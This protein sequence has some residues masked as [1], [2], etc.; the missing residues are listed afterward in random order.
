MM[1]LL[2]SILTD[3]S[4]AHK[5]YSTLTLVTRDG[6]GVIIH[7]A[8]LLVLE[9]L[10]KL[11]ENTRIQLMWL[12]KELIKT[13]V[14]GTD[15]LCFAFLKQMPAG[16]T[17]PADVWLAENLL[18]LFL[19]NMA[20][21]EAQP[22]L[23]ISVVFTYLS[24]LPTHLCVSSLNQLKNEE[25]NFLISLLRNKFIE[26]IQ[27]GRDLIRLLQ[28]VS[29]VPEFTHFW[30]DLLHHPE[31][32]DPSF[33]GI[34]QVLS[35]RTSR[36]FV[37]GRI[38]TDSEIK[39]NFLLSKVKFGQHKR[40]QEW[41]SKKYLST[42]ES[43]TVIPELIR[44]V[45]CVIHPPNE[46]LGSDI[47]PRWA[48]IGWLLTLAQPHPVVLAD[49]KLALF[50]DWLNYS[51]NTDN[52]MNIEPAA[53]LMF[54]SLRSHPQMTQS[55]LDFLC[56]LTT[57]FNPQ[58]S[59]GGGIQAAFHDIVSKGV[60]ASLDPLLCSPR[61]DQELRELIKTTFPSLYP[62][63]QE[64]AVTP[65]TDPEVNSVVID[66]GDNNEEEDDDCLVIATDEELT[67]EDEEIAS[68]LLHDD[69]SDVWA[70]V[71]AVPSSLADKMEKLRANSD[72]VELLRD[73]LEFPDL[74]DYTD[75]II[76][77]LTHCLMDDFDLPYSEVTHDRPLG[78]LLRSNLYQL[79]SG[80]REC[81]WKMGY[82]IL[83]YHYHSDSLQYATYSN[84]LPN[85]SKL[86]TILLRDL[87]I[88]ADE[89][90]E[91]F[92]TLLPVLY[93][94]FPEELVG[95]SEMI[96]IIVSHIDPYQLNSLIIKLSLKKLI[97]FGKP[98]LQ[99]IVGN[100]NYC[101]LRPS[102]MRH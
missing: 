78:V 60:L 54:H 33:T 44:F 91:L 7:V 71:S 50:Y 65:S 97:L 99:D 63:D 9:K 95:S 24:I 81:Q 75:Y 25:I 93:A 1:A 87:K 49:A 6:M 73:I 46:V 85:G 51:S 57:Q 21:L 55:L 96:N 15:R 4:L 72:S 66:V 10:P 80:I 40:Y 94:E 101:K 32:L 17:A 48:F 47:L 102:S 92:F 89:D 86:Q 3:P 70:N 11:L 38:V 22:P 34:G 58:S 18:H 64:V 83:S 2:F 84:Y 31:R 12:T 27:I 16:S 53:L 13:G 59:I 29:R 5:S 74:K 23:I 20:W 35:R 43:L 77:P 82:Y 90:N 98:H 62:Q 42:N 45:C 68:I 39:V 37:A 100:T 67:A 19:D 28:N 41:F 8:E 69:N 61:L 26:C 30:Y 52:I 56:R 79:M 36:R 76:K 88:C 14:S